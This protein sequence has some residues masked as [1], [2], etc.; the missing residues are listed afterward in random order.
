[1]ARSHP[2]TIGLR[3][4]DYGAGKQTIVVVD[5]NPCYIT[6]WDTV[7]W[8]C[9]EGFPF[10][11]HFDPL[12]PLQNRRLRSVEADGGTRVGEAV[13]RDILPGK[14]RY[15]VAVFHEGKIYTEDPELIDENN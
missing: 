10:A 12:S 3:E 6:R 1:V 5:P 7:E 13:R 14:Y 9:R 4:I 15:L 2:I 8:F 11:I